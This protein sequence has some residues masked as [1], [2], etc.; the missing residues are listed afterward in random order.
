MSNTV[1][2][3]TDDFVRVPRL[4]VGGA[5]WVLY[6]DRL[7]WAAD[8]KGV[9]GHLDGTSKE[10]EPPRQTG[11]AA[12]GTPDSTQTQYEADFAAWRKGE[13]TAKQLVASTIPDSLFMKVRSRG[14]AR[15]IWLAITAEFEKKSRM[16]TVDL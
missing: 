16:V 10:P 12:A 3:G 9:L 11:Q 4:E 1:K 14:T 5:N 6:K 13:A 15:A 2:V 8:A 7:L